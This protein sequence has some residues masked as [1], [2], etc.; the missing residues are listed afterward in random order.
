MKKSVKIFML[1]CGIIFVIGLVSATI[2][3]AGNGLNPL[4]KQMG[5]GVYT[6]EDLETKTVD[7]DKYNSIKL[8]LK[9][10]DV[11]FVDSKEYK[12]ECTYI[13]DYK[14]QSVE[15]KN[16]K[17]TISDA[18]SMEN[19][20]GL[21]SLSPSHE[22]QKIT[23]YLP[24]NKTLTEGNI[25]IEEGDIF[26]ANNESLRIDNLWLCN[27][28]GDINLQGF[29]GATA[30][31][32]ASDGSVDLSKSKIGEL[33]TSNSYGDINLA[34]VTANN[35]KI[36]S[37]DG[38]IN[39][40]KAVA[41]NIVIEEEYGDIQMQGIKAKSVIAEIDDGDISAKGIKVTKALKLTSE[42]GGIN[43]SG[44]IKGKTKIETEDGE[45][46]LNINGNKR[47]YGFS[48]EA[49]DGASFVDGKE[50]GTVLSG[51]GKAPANN[52]E[53]KAE[54]GDITLNFK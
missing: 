29:V 43:V 36:S 20:N 40:E 1:V 24:L 52:L 19:Q 32:R 44:V 7:V 46:K 50:Y 5:G 21:I 26:V 15:S 54:S 2:G 39:L 28:Y 51:E 16:G 13:A 3:L 31:I 25:N 37:A 14:M 18:D 6:S 48:L 12:V 47:D 41:N 38:S 53:L 10:S 11:E 42:Y 22:N 33:T 17:L 9:Y 30:E 35:I 8:D 23:V 27:I 4:L 34:G 49:E 45:I